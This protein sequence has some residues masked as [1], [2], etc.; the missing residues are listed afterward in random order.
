MGSTICNAC[1]LYYKLHGVH[2]PDSMKKT[3]IKR[4]KRVPAAA[5][6]SGGHSSGT[7]G[8]I[9]ATEVGDLS[10]APY[11][12]SLSVHN[13]SQMQM[14]DRAAAE[15]LVA[16][17]RVRR[18]ADSERDF[19]STPQR[20]ASPDPWGDGEPKRKRQR[21]GIDGPVNDDMS[22]DFDMDTGHPPRSSQRNHSQP[23]KQRDSPVDAARVV[24]KSAPSI[25]PPPSER[26]ETTTLTLSNSSV[27][28][29]LSRSG[30]P[31]DHNARDNGFSHTANH[32]QSASHPPSGPY[33]QPGTHSN[34]GYSGQHRH[35]SQSQSQ[36]QAAASPL[37]ST[38]S[39]DQAPTHIHQ[40]SRG[41][42]QARNG[43][44]THTS[45]SD[46]RNSHH[47]NEHWKRSRN[48]NGNGV[49][50]PPLAD[51]TRDDALP[52]STRRPSWSPRDEAAY[53]GPS[54]KHRGSSGASPP[55]PST[56]SLP[57]PA[58][59]TRSHVQ[60][61]PRAHHREDTSEYV[62][63]YGMHRMS[64]NESRSTSGNVPQSQV[65]HAS[66]ASARHTHS[67]SPEIS[68]NHHRVYSP[69]LPSQPPSS[70][71]PSRSSPVLTLSELEAHYRELRMQKQV[72][73][74]MLDKTERLMD[75]LRRNIEDARDRE[76][77][78][79]STGPIPAS[80]PLPDRGS[81]GLKNGKDRIWAFHT[82]GIDTNH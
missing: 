61:S 33:S 14:T 13:E 8:K 20:F 28:R 47:N 80:I 75:G 42:S 55:S 72:M 79:S 69:R 81:A 78:P 73:E 44:S 66:H 54:V 60:G 18:H 36:S 31:I 67:T 82:N 59:S 22:P 58:A 24:D 10:G 6:K 63:G 53:T 16:V 19:S 46:S 50:L 27:G 30:T 43:S 71:P 39:L 35:H 41:Y 7:D 37:P 25:P 1:G 65:H 77:R 48:G 9:S 23:M 17:G 64:S 11:H 29:G 3:V 5:S 51:L 56:P 4:R 26:L 74:E 32:T 45:E 38:R 70:R 34:S 62:N 49:D 40:E 2:R 52:N 21:K 12:P 15:A 76:R 57:L 68:T